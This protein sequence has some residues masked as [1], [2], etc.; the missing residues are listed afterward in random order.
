M[1]SSNIHKNNRFDNTINT[2]TYRKLLEPE[3]VEVSS[4][5]TKHK[6]GGLIFIW[7]QKRK[8]Y[9]QNELIFSAW[10]LAQIFYWMQL[11]Q[12]IPTDHVLN[13]ECPPWNYEP[14]LRKP[15]VR[16]FIIEPDWDS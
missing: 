12:I 15:K 16:D 14:P 11:I 6:K 8:F 2:S 7:P 5:E 10:L 3:S 4:E 1:D 9:R 13:I